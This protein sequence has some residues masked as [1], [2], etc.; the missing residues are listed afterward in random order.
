MARPKTV[1]QV[2]QLQQQP[3]LL[4]M[5]AVLVPLPAL[6]QL[7]LQPCIGLTQLVEQLPELIEC[8]LD[9]ARFELDLAL[10]GSDLGQECE[11]IGG[12]ARRI[13]S[14]LVHCIQVGAEPLHELL[15]DCAVH[16]SRQPPTAP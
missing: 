14:W 10:E 2:E 11:Q 5:A 1:T 3:T 7:L 15:L 6:I 12:L 4:E 16:I 9:L 13:G 8:R